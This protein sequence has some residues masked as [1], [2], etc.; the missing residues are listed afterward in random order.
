MTDPMRELKIRAE[1]LHKKIQTGDP[2]ALK[3]LRVLPEFRRNSPESLAKLTSTI[4][5]RHCLAV[6]AAELGFQSWHDMKAVLSGQDQTAGF[7]SLLCPERCVVHLNLWYKTYSEAAEMQKQR[8]SYLLAYRKQYL[9]VDRYYIESL[10]LDPDDP[11]WKALGY[12]WVRPR[13]VGARTNL[14]AKLVAALPRES[15]A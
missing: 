9:V 12:D 8:G 7:G 10:G 4:R 1:L 2:S 5:R 13:D 14:Y 15:A 6:I 11:D 3:R